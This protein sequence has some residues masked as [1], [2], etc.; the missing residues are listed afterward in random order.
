MRILLGYTG[1]VLYQVNFAILGM[2]PLLSPE[3]L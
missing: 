1:Q 2:D 3:L